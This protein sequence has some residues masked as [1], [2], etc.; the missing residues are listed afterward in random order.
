MAKYRITSIPQFN[1][2]GIF[3]RKKS[4]KEPVT[5]SGWDKP[6]EG[7][8][9]LPSYLYT[10]NIPQFEVNN[11]SNVYTVDPVEPLTEMQRYN[12]LP[13]VWDYGYETPESSKEY[14]F[15]SGIR[16]PWME[17]AYMNSLEKKLGIPY[18]GPGFR[19][20][21]KHTVTITTPKS[22]A[23]DRW[24]S[25]DATG[26][27]LKCPQG[28]VAYMG[29]C[30]SEDF[31]INTIMKNEQEQED[32]KNQQKQYERQEKWRK[33]EEERQKE[34][35][36]WRDKMMVYDNERYVEDFKNTK[37]E[38]SFR[39]RYDISKSDLN[40]DEKVD[41]TD[42]NGDVVI[43]NKTGKPKQTTR[44]E[45]LQKEYLVYDDK[46]SGSV[47][48]WPLEVVANRIVNN[49]FT[50]DQFANW[51]GIKDKSQVRS[52]VGEH[53][54]AAQ[55]EHNARIEERITKLA[56]ERGISP[57]EAAKLIPKTWATSSGAQS[58]TPKVKKTIDDAYEAFV[59]EQLAALEKQ[60]GDIVYQRD[61]DDKKLGIYR[62]KADYKPDLSVDF[63]FDTDANIDTYDETGKLISREFNPTKAYAKKW[64]AAAPNETERKRRQAIY[65]ASFTTQVEAK[66]KVYNKYG[67]TNLG[68]VDHF[69]GM[70][71]KEIATVYGDTFQQDKI[72]YGNMNTIGLRMKAH[73]EALA[74]D[75]QAQSDA[76]TNSVPSFKE[77]FSKW[78]NS[79]NAAGQMQVYNRA[80]NNKV[81]TADKAKVLGLLKKEYDTK[82]TGLALDYILGQQSGY[83]PNPNDLNT[84]TFAS[85][86]RYYGSGDWYDN[87]LKQDK[88]TQGKPI[89]EIGLGTKIWDVLTNPGDALYYAMNGR[90]DRM[91]GNRAG[92]YNDAKENERR[93]GVDLGTYKDIGPMTMILDMANTLSPLNWADETARAYQANGWTG[94]GARSKELA[95]DAIETASMFTPAGLEYKLA[96]EALMLRNLANAGKLTGLGK[97]AN[98]L[99]RTINTVE[100]GVASLGYPGKY[101]VNYGR[102]MAPLFAIEALRP[103]G[104][105]HQGIKNFSEGDYL[106]GIGRTLEGASYLL[107]YANKLPRLE[108]VSPTGKT[109]GLGKI[110]NQFP[111]GISYASSPGSF[112]YMIS[113]IP[114][115]KKEFTTM[116]N[117]FHPD[118][119][120][121][122]GITPSINQMEQLRNATLT[123]QG[124]N[125][126]NIPFSSTLEQ[127]GK[128]EPRTISLGSLGK[129]RVG[130]PVFVPTTLQEASGIQQLEVPKKT[131]YLTKGGK[132]FRGRRIKTNNT[133][134]IQD[135]FEHGGETGVGRII[136]GLQ[137][138]GAPQYRTGGVT[139]NLSPDEISKYVAGGFIIEDE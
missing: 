20:E 40:L 13:T 61:A 19:P 74:A 39:P 76:F 69:K 105:F 37:K 83:D 94:V 36:E 99:A 58:F 34:Q 78:A 107:P 87:Y 114:Q 97:T 89:Q 98:N 122:L 104:I 128:L 70:S 100:R 130:D 119:F 11:N 135:D 82:K 14:T 75:Q 124:A 86:L 91:W 118:K 7:Q 84:P 31:A 117:A 59:K 81:S 4:K 77:D 68:T 108:Y 2:G 88:I 49:G 53:I 35:A 72:A 42:E 62:T 112:R 3:K 10:E 101:L 16:N 1:E 22:F 8:F 43:D 115:Y 123:Y 129:M 44:R 26:A 63:D 48:L 27:P 41:L 55:A 138:L 67:L 33:E 79:K 111:E 30:W 134:S 47:K 126:K 6:V 50:E 60:F 133:E 132:L 137:N 106:G 64:V 17:G 125:Y 25:V 110:R 131:K 103:E 12:T 80:L 18:K 38:E 121:Y 120:A 65:N 127:I 56:I 92:S 139:M 51:W 52:Q 116:Q 71:S 24:A 96:K 5:Q 90:G 66:N 109:F 95:T 136:K 32:W 113:N 73:D 57:T 54:D 15:Y 102:N 45:I 23:E 21:D 29:Q 9:T 28:Q 93:F 85:D 46:E